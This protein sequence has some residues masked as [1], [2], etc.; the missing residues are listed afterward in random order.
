MQIDLHIGNGLSRK[1]ERCF[2]GQFVDEIRYAE[3]IA[4]AVEPFFESEIS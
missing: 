4:Y 2:V 1:F 3:F